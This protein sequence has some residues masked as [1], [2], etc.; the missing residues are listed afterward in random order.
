METLK[1]LTLCI[2]LTNALLAPPSFGWIKVYEK[3]GV[4]YIIGEGEKIFKKP[5]RRKLTS[6]KEKV[7]FYAKKYGIP[8]KLFLNL[9]KA[10]SNFNP[11]AVS[12]KGA[13]GL[14]QL[15]PET[16]KEFGV[17][18]VFDIDE[19]LDAGAR[20]LKQL[21]KKYRSWKLA[22][23]AYNAG[24]KTVDRY[25]G[26]PPYRETRNYVKK[27]LSGKSWKTHS[28][29]YRIVMKKKGDTILIM[30]QFIE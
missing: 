18:N 25:G 17:K 21:Y 4:I 28:R 29:K 7:K 14:C 27:V 3:N 5:D 2:F 20:Y 8:E 24:S 9:V 13:K 23:A 30:Q 19:N 1:K 22:L 26:I 6:I 12:P 11:K 16:A 10:E 15:M